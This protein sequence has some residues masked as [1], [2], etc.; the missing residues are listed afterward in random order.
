MRENRNI[1]TSIVKTVI[2][3]ASNNIPLRGYFEDKRNFMKLLQFSIDA[4]DEELKKHFA[5][6]AGNK[7]TSP[8]FQNE[9]LAIARNMIVQEIVTKAIK[10]FSVSVIAD[11]SCD[12][13]GKEQLSNVSR[14]MI[15]SNLEFFLECGMAGGWMSS[16][17]LGY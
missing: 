3:C 10:S 5:Q 7:Y 14:Y 8:M 6:M 2:F 13:S 17:V 15:G 9:I 12:I 11:K 4:E 16:T 1:I